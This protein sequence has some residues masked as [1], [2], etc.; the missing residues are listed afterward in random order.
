MEVLH[1]HIIAAYT[2]KYY[3]TTMTILCEIVLMLYRSHDHELQSYMLQ[4]KINEQR[5]IDIT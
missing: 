5:M 2:Y 4:Y 1:R 3:N